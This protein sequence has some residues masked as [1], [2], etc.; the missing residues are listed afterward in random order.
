M[1]TWVCW[2]DDASIDR[3]RGELEVP[4][5]NNRVEVPAEP[6]LPESHV[7][8]LAIDSM[9]VLARQENP[10]VEPERLYRLMN[11]LTLVC[12]PLDS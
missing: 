9:M 10:A 6:D 7:R 4:E 11:E 2:L 3:F 8:Q 5:I 12:E 1:T